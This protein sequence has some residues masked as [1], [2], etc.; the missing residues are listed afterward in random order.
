MSFFKQCIG[1]F[2]VLFGLL[3]LQGGQSLLQIREVSESSVRIAAGATLATQS[4]DLWD[5]FRSAD[6]EI[7]RAL[8]FTDFTSGDELSARVRPRI[9][10]LNKLLDEMGKED[11]SPALQ[12][13]RTALEKWTGLVLPHLSSQGV[14]EV[15]SYDVLDRVREDLAK[16]IDTYAT[17][18]LESARTLVAESQSIASSATWW[19]VG[20]LTV[21]LLLCALLGWYAIRTLKARLGGEPD[22]VAAAARRLARGDLSEPVAVAPG[23]QSSIAAAMAQMQ[24]SLQAFVSEEERL[25]QQHAAGW[26]DHAMDITRFEGAYREMAQSINAI[27]SEHVAVGMRVI[28]LVRQYADGDF[29]VELEALP[30]NRAQ[31]NEAMTAVKSNLLSINDEIQRLVQAASRGDFS[32]RGDAQKYDHRF[33]EMVQGL[34]TLMETSQSGLNDVARVLMALSRGDLTQRIDADYQGT[35]G[36]LKDDANRTVDSLTTIVSQI[37]ATTESITR[38]SKEI[39]QGNADL[40]ARTEQQAGSLEQTASSMEEFTSTVKQNA[41]NARQANQLAIGAADV[42]VKGGEVVGEVVSTMGSI[43]ESSKKI[44]DIISVI[45]GIAFQTNILALNAAVEAARAGE[46]GRGFAV[47]AT[48]VRNLA[49][50]SAAA[51]KEIKGLI[52]DSVEKVDAGSRLVDQ[53]GA[54][55]SQVVASIKRVTDIVAEITVASQ[56]QSSG[57]E[58]VNEAVTQM[59][60]TTQQNAALVEEAA[61]AAESLQEQAGVLLTAVA[62]FQLQAGSAGPEARV[63]RRGPN[64]AKNVTRLPAGRA[65]GESHSGSSSRVAPTAAKTGTDGDWAEF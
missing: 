11:K 42:A 34:N 2:A 31:I 25:A 12:E 7:R 53:A 23:D 40:S 52:S 6:Q 62:Q 17:G 49:Q 43:N 45:D 21:G 36:Q 3:A 44:V 63:E 50:R 19:I 59:D 46:Q 24:T 8:E 64:R 61:A 60:E 55:M 20:E 32:A 35:F 33:R 48:E 39:A 47:V 22:V 51:A 41:E 57:I 38:G 28:E 26:T 27:T 18:Q 9:E 10:R 1:L 15:A 16:R 14:T 37:R 56:E 4:R 54:T 30:G 58:Q 5:E 13:V 29:S 65:A